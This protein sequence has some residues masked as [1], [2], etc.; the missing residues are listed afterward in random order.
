MNPNIKRYLISS[1]T[2]F[3][4][5]FLLV[6]SVAVQVPTFTLSKSSIL[7]AASAALYAAVRAVGKFIQEVITGTHSDIT[8]TPTQ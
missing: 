8:P 5:S 2:T 3:A 4:T 1:L 7:A 6:I